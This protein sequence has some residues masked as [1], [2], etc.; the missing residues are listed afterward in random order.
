MSSLRVADVHSR[1]ARP[2]CLAPRTAGSKR[3]EMRTGNTARQESRSS[4]LMQQRISRRMLL[5]TKLS[6]NAA[7]AGSLA[8]FVVSRSHRYFCPKYFRPDPLASDD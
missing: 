1:G 6:C 7:T 3:R 8:I 5:N 4:T 2:H